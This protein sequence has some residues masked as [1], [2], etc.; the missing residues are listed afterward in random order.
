MRNLRATYNQAVEQGLTSQNDPFTRVYTGIAKTVKRVVNIGEVQK[1]K[2]HKLPSDATGGFSR[3]I[4]L[5]SLH[6][7]G[8]SLIDIAHLEKSDL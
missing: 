5:F 6:T 3:D 1:T 4:F 8:M 7:C 2:A